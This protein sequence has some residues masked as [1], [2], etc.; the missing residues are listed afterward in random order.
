MAMS[1]ATLRQALVALAV[2][3]LAGADAR[4]DGQIYEFS[5]GLDGWTTVPQTGAA[6][7]ASGGALIQ[8]TTDPAPGAF[9]PVIFAGAS[10]DGDRYK[11]LAMKVTVTGAP[12][13]SFHGVVRAYA[14]AF[15]SQDF[16]L[17]NGT[18]VVRL[19][20]THRGTVSSLELDMPVGGDYTA[21][22]GAAIKIHWLAVTDDPQFRGMAPER[23]DPD[24]PANANGLALASDDRAL[25]PGALPNYVLTPAQVGY[26]FGSTVMAD[27]SVLFTQYSGGVLQVVPDAHGQITLFSRVLRPFQLPAGLFSLHLASGALLAGD[28]GTNQI[29]RLGDNALI[30]GGAGEVGPMQMADDASG[31]LYIAWAGLGAG[32]G[33]LQKRSPGGALTTV[34]GN[35]NLPQGVAVTGG[36]VH[37]TTYTLTDPRPDPEINGTPLTDYVGGVAGNGRLLRAPGAVTLQGATLDGYWRN[38]GMATDTRP[39]SPFAGQLYIVEEANAWDQGNSARITRYDPAAST[40]TTVLQGL[41]YPEFPSFSNHDGRL[42]FNLAHDG[43]GAAFDPGASFSPAA[44]GRA[45]VAMSI[46][47]GTWDPSVVRQTITLY[48]PAHPGDQLVLAGTVT[49]APQVNTV[50]GW[51]RVPDTYFPRIAKGKTCGD[52]CFTVPGVAVG[53]SLGRIKAVALA[54]RKHRNHPRWPAGNAGWTANPLFDESP[55]EYVVFFQWTYAGVAPGNSLLIA[56]GKLQLADTFDAGVNGRTSTGEVPATGSPELQVERVFGNAPRSWPAGLWALHRDGN[57]WSPYPG[58]SNNGSAAGITQSVAA[59]ADWG[60]A[61][62]LASDFIVQ[63][64]WVQTGDRVDLT[65]SNVPS[66]IAGAHGISVFFRA[67]GSALPEVGIYNAAVGELPALDAGSGQPIR[68][69]IAAGTWHNYAVRFDLAGG[70]LSVYVDEELRGIVNLATFHGGV[71]L[72]KLDAST[73]DFVS[74]GYAQAAFGTPVWSD[75]F[76]VGTP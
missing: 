64:D 12:A 57:A 14:G 76:Q 40:S 8:T 67:S 33:F 53:S 3:V 4:A 5:S 52:G 74:V 47:G 48:D 65:A 46:S 62:D 66:S 31:N 29:R 35:I 75:N 72:G 18:Q 37:Y 41:D 43:Y 27:G 38:R 45:G 71:L 63:A 22:R 11:Q 50:S 59:S 26:G 19:V 21:F 70:Y 32:P 68:S 6:L 73:N 16:T 28:A 25:A 36:A 34:D 42:Y 24:N 54:L 56:P 55:E 9:G 51:F 13:G 20:M 60:V 23:I 1:H 49:P 69:G 58:T 7:A 44:S 2:L 10:Y 30:A 61:Y 39:G 15:T 17:R